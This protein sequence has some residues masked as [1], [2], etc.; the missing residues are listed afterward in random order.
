MTDSV[1]I[2]IDPGLAST[3]FAL[4]RTEGSRLF[5][6]EAGTL[7]TSP[8]TPH[9]ERLLALCEGIQELIARH[10]V[11]AAA[12]ERWFVHPVSQAAMGMAEAR[13]ALLVALASGSIPVTEYSPNAI[14]QSV[15]GNGR[16]DKAQVRAMVGRLCGM[17]PSTDHAADALAAAICHLS[18]EP[19]ARAVGGGR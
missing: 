17:V 6:V 3:G 16:A 11:R 9:A 13:G 10:V 4:V 19:F 1:V 12:V 5:G 15:T 7:R 2:G 18:S 14:K 8:R